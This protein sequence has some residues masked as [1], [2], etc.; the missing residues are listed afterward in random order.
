M[1]ACVVHSRR[2]ASSINAVRHQS[3]RA[4]FA[5]TRLACTFHLPKPALAAF[6]EEPCVNRQHSRRRW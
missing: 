3:L 2:A 1:H 4:P 5:R 6:L